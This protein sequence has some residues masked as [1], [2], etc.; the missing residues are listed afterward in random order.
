[1]TLVDK[2]N[3]GAGCGFHYMFYLNAPATGANN[4]VVSSGG[5]TYKEACAVSYTGV[6]QTGQ[7]ETTPVKNSASGVSSLS[8][9]VTTIANQAWAVMVTQNS[10]GTPTAGAGTTMRSNSG[11]GG[12][13]DSNAGLSPGSNALVANMPPSGNMGNILVSIA[14]VAAS[15]SP[16]MRTL[17][18]AGQ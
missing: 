17:M 10:N 13:L 5:A 4:V 1:M 12:I 18:G 9:S 8:T 16:P 11:A 3:P 6:S 7:P 2:Q 14:P 15:A